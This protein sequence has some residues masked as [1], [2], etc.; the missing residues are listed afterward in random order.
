MVSQRRLLRLLD[1][2]RC[3]HF[4][5]SH[6]LVSP[7][8]GGSPEHFSR[9]RGRITPMPCHVLRCDCPR[10]FTEPASI[11]CP[12]CNHPYAGRSSLEVHFYAKHPGLSVRE[13]SLYLRAAVYPLGLPA[14]E[15][16]DPDH[17]VRPTG[18]IAEV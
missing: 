10:F 2:L 7:A 17:S 5:A 3:H 4:R 8:F 14:D 1:C 18:A 6:Y 15:N 9:P 12:I 11:P 16:M 13:R